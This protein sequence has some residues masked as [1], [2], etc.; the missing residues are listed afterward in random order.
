MKGKNRLVPRLLGI[1]KDSVVRLDERTKEVVK[2]WPLTS[3]LKWAASPNAFTMVH[4]F[5]Y[6]ILLLFRWSMPQ[7]VFFGTYRINRNKAVLQW[8]DLLLVLA[9]TPVD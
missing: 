7:R 3:I 2:V 4:R 9:L 1:T 8:Q 5:Q 6:S